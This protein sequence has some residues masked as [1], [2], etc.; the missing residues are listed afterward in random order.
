V[1]LKWHHKSYD[2]L[3]DYNVTGVFMR[4]WDIADEKGFCSAD[5]DAEDA[6][7]VCQHIGIPFHEINFVKEYWNDVFRLENVCA[8]SPSERLP[9]RY[10]TMRSFC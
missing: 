3:T 10:C 6:A 1:F 7:Y 5:T 9:Y 8:L 2:L 4:N